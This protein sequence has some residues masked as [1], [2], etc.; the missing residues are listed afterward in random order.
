MIVRALLGALGSIGTLAS[1]AFAQE[2]I[3]LPQPVT[4]PPPV[5][6]P[7]SIPAC[8]QP[9]PIN[10]PT[11]LSLAG[12]R[13]LDI[14]LASERI[15]VAAAQLQ[16]ARVLWLPTVYAGVDYFRHDGQI[17][18]VAG[19]ILGTSKS[20][21]AA[22]AG[23]VAVFAISDA[24]FGPLA[25][26]QDLR[27][28]E[29]A[30]Q[31]ARNDTLLSVAESYFNVQQARGELAGAEETARRAEDLVRRTEK[32]SPG[33]IP[34]VEVSRTRVEASRRRQAVH[35]ARE[36]WLVASAD[37]ARLLRLDASALVE[38]MEPPQLQVTL[39]PLDCQVDAL[40]P[41]ALTN[42]PELAGQQAVVQATLERLRQEKLRPLIP[43][44]LL[45]GATT[46]PA[47]ILA[48]G[49]FG[50]GRNDNLSNFGAR[51]DIDVQLLWELQNLGFGNRARVNERKAE[52]ELALIELFRIQDHIAAEV[53]QSHAQVQSASARLSEAEIGVKDAIESANS[54]LEGVGQTQG[55]G[56]L[57]L[58]IR[59][60]EAVAAVQALAQAYA[61]YYSSV[62][63]YDR[64]QF[65]LYRAL[66]Q[67]A[68]SLTCRPQEQEPE[69]VIHIDVRPARH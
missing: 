16:R 11:A 40:I 57:V 32:L 63:E 3:A 21:F 27:V 51:F 46:N 42:R 13:P 61:D 1:L 8:K 28:R 56:K 26:R 60:Q 6:A 15:A 62:A 58:L 4:S 53:V 2:Q 17:Q 38:P 5:L 34:P 30:M 14:S 9:L 20:T 10:L 67:P 43:S 29:A 24:I 48:G 18:D 33:L 35:S 19:N 41:V 59:P 47:G 50:G 12:V 23:P 64:A 44:L 65:R 7:A 36:R 22:G 37:L 31:T 45:R 69:S 25:A 68:Q 54:N 66:G 52:R 49:V 39:V 55:T